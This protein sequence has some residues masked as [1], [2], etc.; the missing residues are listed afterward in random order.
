MASARAQ[1]AAVVRNGVLRPGPD[2][3]YA[4]GDGD[5]DDAAWLDV[6]WQA[7]QRPLE[8]LGRRVNVLDTG[9]PASGAGDDPPLLFVHC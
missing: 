3:T 6:D 4:D 1:I 9:E 2:A 8:L 7:L 5:G